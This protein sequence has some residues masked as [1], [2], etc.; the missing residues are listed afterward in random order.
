MDAVRD[1]FSCDTS[2]IVGS[3]TADGSVIFAKNSDRSPNECQPLTHVAGRRHRPGDTVRCQYLEI[4]QVAE[5]WEVIGSRPY[6]L[7]GF[8]I[9]VNEWGVAIGNEAVH[10]REPYEELALIGMDLV[11]LGLERA[12]SADEAVA[13]I[14]ELVER[15]GQGGSCEAGFFRTYQNSFIVADRM[16][17][18]VLE[19][20]GHRWVAERVVDRAAISNLLT[21]RGAGDRSSPGVE[22]HARSQG[23]VDGSYD[24]AAAYQDTEA[25]LTPRVCRL[26]RARAVLGG[27]RLPVKVRDMMALLRDHGDGDL[28]SSAQPLPSICMH[29][30]PRYPG[31]TAAAMVIQLR[32]DGPRE[33]AVTCWTAFGSPCLSIFRPVYPFAVGLPADLDRGGST[34]DAASPWWLFE[35]LQRLVAQAPSLAEEVRAAFAV[36]E[37]S[38][39]A[40]AD[41]A[42]ADALDA[43]SLGDREG[44]LLTLRS[45]VDS[46]TRRAIGLAEQLTIDVAVRSRTNAVLAMADFWAALNR[47]AGMIGE[48]ALAE[49]AGSAR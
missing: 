34:F 14:G 11:R 6:W 25:D 41:Q 13:V 36:L 47:D 43:L 37:D 35:Q 40:E 28:P 2:V 5:T 32:P 4:P 42:E 18:W 49:F 1:A 19:T 16:T 21:I 27:Y 3:A 22:E 9:G 38:F 8:E 44:A 26:D 10:T 31:E 33:L 15:Y 46:T 23:W 48:E 12:K 30:N 29:A 45:L 20:A 24:F 39:F 7:W 17:A